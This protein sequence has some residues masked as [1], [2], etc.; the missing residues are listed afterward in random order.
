MRSRM[1]DI[2]AR[3]A[4]SRVPFVE[5]LVLLTV[6]GLLWA[7]CLPPMPT[8]VAGITDLST[9]F[10]PEG[11]VLATL[12]AL[13]LRR[14]AAWRCSVGMFALMVMAALSLAIA[15][16]AVDRVRVASLDLGGW[17]STWTAL[18]YAQV[19]IF[20]LASLSGLRQRRFVRRWQRLDR[21]LGR[22]EPTNEPTSRR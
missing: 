6:T 3:L 8:Y 20:V 5:I 13:P 4:P 15:D 18:A 7:V 2:E 16:E 14:V 21:K 1:D 9:V 12:L 10:R 22:I 17:E 19:A 11:L